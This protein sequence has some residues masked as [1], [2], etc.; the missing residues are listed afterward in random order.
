MPP[1][2]VTGN[3]GVTITFVAAW[4]VDGGRIE[5]AGAGRSRDLSDREGWHAA[6]LVALK[7]DVVYALALRNGSLLAATGNRGRVYRVEREDAGAIYRCG[8]SGGRTRNGVCTREGRVCWWRRATAARCFG[9]AMRTAKEST[10]TSEVFDA[11]G[12]A[13]WGRVETRA[14]AARRATNFGCGAEMSRA[15]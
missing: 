15:R 12:Y 8:A 3:V 6:G 5:F 9:W 11:Q 14:E 4:V 10:Y 13:Q 2:P 7:D 1:L